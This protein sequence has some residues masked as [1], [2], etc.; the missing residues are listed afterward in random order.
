M[1][2]YLTTSAF[3]NTISVGMMLCRKPINRYPEI[4]MKKSL[5][6]AASLLAMSAAAQAFTGASQ[7]Y[8][9]LAY[10]SASYSDGEIKVRPG[11]VRG[12]AGLE[13]S[14]GLA[15]E[16]MFGAGVR[17]GS[18]GIAGYTAKVGVDYAYGVYVKPKLQ[19]TPE[20]ELFGRVGYVRTKMSVSV[21]GMSMST[22]DGDVS[23]GAGLK[24]ALTPQWSASADYMSYG[25]NDG[26]K[27][28]GFSLGL[29]YK[30]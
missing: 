18:F 6:I 28:T 23:Y 8:G 30:F 21:A 12:I 26:A 22:T 7:A 2:S 9:E 16:A 19:I 25:K 3:D 24:Y 5:L 27:G 17:D 13:Y 29:G 14:P 15:F 11:V 1:V 10:T 20:L 4:Q